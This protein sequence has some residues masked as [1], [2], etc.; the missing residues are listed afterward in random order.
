MG[1]PAPPAV[2]TRRRRWVY[3]AVVTVLVVGAIT[4]L[5]YAFQS[6]QDETEERVRPAAI[7]RVFP[8]EDAFSLRQDA[9]GFELACGYDGVLLVDGGEVPLDQLQRQP[10]INRFSWTPGV[11][12][13][14]PLAAGPHTATAVYWRATEGRDE[15]RRYTWRFTAS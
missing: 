9:I 6:S 1:M 14:P 13:A 11:G 3:P 8:V 10:G 15:S 2:E 4:A 5:V 7:V 12:D